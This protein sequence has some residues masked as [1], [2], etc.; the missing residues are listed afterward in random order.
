MNEFRFANLSWLHLIW[1]IVA[2]VGLLVVLEL[3]G[4][5]LLD[6]MISPLMQRRLVEKS[7]IWTRLVSIALLFISSLFFIFAMMR[8]QWGMTVQT[9]SKVDSQIMICLDVS[10]SMLAEDVVPNRLERAKAEIDSLL[11]LMDDGQQVG[12]I[13]FAGRASV[14][15]PMTT[16][17]GFLRLIL[18]EAL[19]STIGLGGTRIGEAID[20]AAD[21]FRSAGDVNRMI[22]LITD[23]EDHDSFPLDA[24]EKAREKGVR[25][26]SVG[27]GDEAG[28][29]IEITDP[30]T[31]AR[32]FVKDR[33]GDD[34]VS[35]LDGTTL[36][37]IALKTEGAYIPAGTGALDLQSIYDAHIKTLLKGTDSEEER[38][39]RNEGYQWFVLLGL[40]FLVLSMMVRTLRTKVNPLQSAAPTVV[41]ACLLS[42]CCGLFPTHTFAAAPN[43][44]QQAAALPDEEVAGREADGGVNSATAKTDGS[45]RSVP[46]SEEGGEG[47]IVEIEQPPRELYNRGMRLISSDPNR[48]ERLLTAARNGAGVDGELRFRSLFNLGWVEVTR[49][50]RLVESDPAQAI[51]HFEIASG[52]FR[53]AVRLRPDDDNARY[54]LEVLAQRILELQDALNQANKKTLEEELDTLIASLREHQAELQNVAA[55]VDPNANELTELRSFF[56]K[57][58]VTQRK[59]ISDSELLSQSARRELDT[60]RSEL[61][62]AN[63][64]AANPN[65]VVVPGN[66]AA[67][68][69]DQEVQQM[70]IRSAQI[71]AMLMY[72][73]RATQRLVKA[74]SFT[75]RSLPQGAFVR[76]SSGLSD[77]KRARDQ[78]RNPIEILGVLLSDSREV[79][80]NTQRKLLG[81]KPSLLLGATDSGG[82][83]ANIP[84]WLTNEYLAESQKAIGER[85]NELY[86]VL[87][88]AVESFS[89]SQSVVEEDDLEGEEAEANADD[90]ISTPTA[91]EESLPGESTLDETQQMF[92]NIKSAVPLIQSAS[93]AFA[94][95]T[96]EISE[97]D[98]ESALEQQATGSQA[99]LDAS[100]Y[101]YD[102]RRLIE[103]MYRDQ[104]LV[105]QLTGSKAAQ[106]GGYTSAAETEDDGEG[107]PAILRSQVEVSLSLLAKNE[108][109]IQ[110][111]SGLIASEMKK[112]NAEQVDG[113]TNPGAANGQGQKEEVNPAMQRFELAGQLR[114]EIERDLRDATRGIEAWLADPETVAIDETKGLGT[115]GSG[116]EGKAEDA[117]PESGDSDG[118]ADEDAKGK[119]SGAESEVID[120]ESEEVLSADAPTLPTAELVRAEENMQELRRLFFSLIEHLRETAQRQGNLLDRSLSELGQGVNQS[121]SLEPRASAISSRQLELNSIA[122]QIAEALSQQAE[123]SASQQPGGAPTQG[124]SQPADAETLSQASGLV[125][126]GAEAMLRALQGLEETI[127]EAE[128]NSAPEVGGVENE[129]STSPE[130]LDSNDLD[131]PNDP[132]PNDLVPDDA[133]SS[134]G[135]DTK[136]VGGDNV[137]SEGTHEGQANPQ[138]RE[139]QGG[140]FDADDAKAAS[141]KLQAGVFE[142]QTT[143]LQKLVEAL[144]LLD[145]QQSG[146]NQDQ[147]QQQQQQQSD[148][149][150]KQDQQQSPQ[151]QQPE[152]NM[153]AS[154][155]LQ[156]IRDREA[157]RREE[158]QRANALTSGG[159]EKDW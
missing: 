71:E 60:L 115:D 151:Q 42:I 157:K 136:Q 95:S 152:Q 74:R 62:T 140:G 130:E 99:L 101:F 28:S 132:A 109:R 46:V 33:N 36:R 6:R 61:K 119:E 30:A 57:L 80:L 67:D 78:L 88:G 111:L 66:Q 91:K 127:A 126:E 37:E 26:V 150:Q 48:A 148:E 3:R 158:K 56:R 106:S 2:F 70:Q 45:N 55:T 38:I 49:G 102:L 125:K 98:L 5:S 124:G 100:E 13:G 29:K 114:D 84:T 73:D 1:G 86:Q 68:E 25:I 11:G 44:W 4:R 31:G 9:M 22:L 137:G 69:S 51:K 54:N 139:S 18:K 59:I 113:G 118:E 90:A 19:P 79:G 123:Q 85:T 110:R 145:Q 131:A 50:D 41:S 93:D 143:A 47:E 135:R 35:S 16:D 153:S 58:G 108:Q 107:S 146:D 27:F 149:S 96:E 12:L 103:V 155:M 138:M 20:K 81:E 116:G 77:T 156:A 141:E 14:L 94:A 121:E 65:S 133:P 39:I 53:E 159:V 63:S 23:G 87:N 8:P 92:A 104:T 43:V 117:E 147:Q 7:S 105:S 72:L 10:K 144:Q 142:P 89:Q 122:T 52:R 128:S 24:A 154:Q 15:C 34:V 129:A 21:G 75:R 82:V 83:D 32:G 64:S 76:W 40:V 112:L 97:G 134:D 17:F 120:P